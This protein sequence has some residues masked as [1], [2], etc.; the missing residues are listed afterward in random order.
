M[1]FIND[2]GEFLISCATSILLWL[3]VKKKSDEQLKVYILLLSAK[4]GFNLKIVNI[5]NCHFQLSLLSF[6][7][8]IL[9]EDL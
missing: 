6:S 5:F 3:N 4:G 1:A 2:N 7:F 8:K 9:E